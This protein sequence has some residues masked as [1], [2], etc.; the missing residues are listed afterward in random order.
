MSSSRLLAMASAV[1]LAVPAV[2]TAPAQAQSTPAERRIEEVV[3]TAQRIEQS[4]QDVPISVAAISGEALDA[5]QIDAFDQLQYVVP[6]LTFSAGVNARQSASTIRGIGTSLFNIGVEGSVAIAVDGVILGREGAGLFDLSDV[7]RVEVLRGPQGTLFGK[8]ASAGVIS[9]TT[10]RP[11]DTPA[12][13]VSVS[14]GTKNEVNLSGAVSG[15][16]AENVRGRLSGYRNTRDGYVT[17]VNP[18]APQS[19]VNERDEYGVR[20]RVDFDVTDSFELSLSADYARRDQASGALTLRSASAGGPGTGL[21]GFG[22]PV[23]GPQTAAAG[24]TP[25]AG[26]RLIAAQGPFESDMKSYGGLVE[27]NLDLGDYSL[28]SLSSYRRWTSVDN[29]DAALIPLPF[30]AV[31]SGDLDQRQYS[32]E[33]RLVSPR[34]RQLT[35][36]L[37]SYFFTQDMEQFN[38]QSGT[39]GLDLLGVIPPGLLLGT[40]LDSTFDETNYA[41]FGQGEYQLTD[42]LALIAGLRVVRS[43][44][45]ASLFRRVTPGSVGPYAGQNVTAVPLAASRN[46]TDVVWRLGAQY[47]VH[48]DLNLFTTIT[49]GYK[50]A[51]IVSGL[52]INATEQG[53]TTLPTVDPEIPLQ[54][55]IGVR[56]RGWDGRL[57]TNLTA[58]YSTIDD[59]QAQALVPGPAGTAIF[60]VTNAGKARTWG[61]EGEVTVLPTS[62]L[63]LSSALAYTR[64]TFRSFDRAPC[65]ALQPVGPDGCVDTTGNGVGEFQDLSG[66]DLAGSPDWVV[67]ALARYD[68]PLTGGNDLFGQLGVSY[69][70]NTFGSNTNDPNTRLDGYALLD[71]QFGLDFRD[72]RGTLTVFGRNLLNKNFVEAIVGQ[73]FDTGGYAQF[74]T[75]ESQR[76]FGARISLRY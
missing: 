11:S 4:I 37:G 69:R 22:L 71:A 7:E 46:D 36:T 45:E 56:S 3:V 41:V 31:N 55:E 23:I 44:L 15:P 70:S 27:G 12:A 17:N 62:Q 24:I 9:I 39:A 73:S 30:L 48:D 21:L 33:I 66:R 60:S 63:T 18:D 74:L 64:A 47:Y 5:R 1:A 16:I 65:Y 34:D 25:G 57:T 42:Q 29:N 19:D 49:R 28:V 20:G 58:F 43:E 40:D 50:A 75:F 14:Y 51:G 10:R 53:G 32:Q 59:F 54:Y 67:N 72:G 35:Y 68:L 38:T 26:N 2:V 61:F 6:G 8:N 52:T 13:N 76:S